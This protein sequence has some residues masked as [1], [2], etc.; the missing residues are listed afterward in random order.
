MMSQADSGRGTVLWSPTSLIV[1]EVRSPQRNEALSRHYNV[2]DKS[3]S[4][5]CLSFKEVS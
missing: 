2:G 1:V 3:G 5:S 4:I